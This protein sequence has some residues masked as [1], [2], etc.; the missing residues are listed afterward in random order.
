MASVS[1]VTVTSSAT[2]ESSSSVKKND[3][4]GK[5][6]FLKLLVAQL[7]YQDPMKPMEDK[8]FI[9]Q[10]AQFSSLEQIQ[11]LNSTMVTMQAMG[12]IGKTVRWQNENGAEQAGN[13]RAVKISD[14]QPYI[15]VG[16]T[17]V[18]LS[19]IQVVEESTKGGS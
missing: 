14:R 11:N 13:V 12:L 7:R 16:D 6:D 17:T 3:Q 8:E 9:A 5:D 15:V 1:S 2:G 18:E 19:K 10:M 4:L